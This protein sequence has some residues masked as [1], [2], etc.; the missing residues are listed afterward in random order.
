MKKELLTKG[1]TT[2]L[3]KTLGAILL[4]TMN[5]L[6][7][8]ALGVEQYGI[9][10]LTIALIM[11]F[12]IP[13]HGG[14]PNLA[15]R[16]TSK[17]IERDELESLVYFWKWCG[18]IILLFSSASALLFFLSLE[19][20]IDKKILL[21]S[22][23]YF[24]LCFFILA[25]ALLTAINGMLRGMKNMLLGNLPEQFIVPT[26]VI[27]GTL[28]FIDK[29]IVKQADDA[30]LL[31]TTS[32]LISL[33]ISL[34]FLLKL[35]NAKSTSSSKKKPKSNKP[36]SKKW[37]NS[38]LPLTFISGIQIISKNL[39]L[40]LVGLILIPEASGIYKVALQLSI[41]TSFGL[42]I[43]NSLISPYIASLHE[44]KSKKK[45]QKLI[46]VSSK[47]STLYSAFTLLIIIIFGQKIISLTFGNEYT[48][49][50]ISLV[51]L[52]VGQLIHSFF[53]PIG[54]LLNMTGN[55]KV[56]L[57]ASIITLIISLPLSILLISLFKEI[58]GAIATSIALAIWNIISWKKAKTILSINTL[59][60]AKKK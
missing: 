4:F 50:Y 58:G 11:I 40:I 21:S 56:V 46:K 16:E 9:Y 47:I 2:L 25:W 6:L 13:A 20:G 29:Q 60:L 39:S 41:T 14:T 24:I 7:A 37:M 57:N 38:L 10:S 36:N 48:H 32:I 42:G 12:S 51:I 43:I 45:L 35:H 15:I 26:I 54:T 22:K 5:I 53:G 1:V 30:I 17:I 27:L 49:A 19:L 52:A 34:V 8:R 18:I 23:T 33:A 3:L 59:Y 55:E 28:F 31:Y 44:K